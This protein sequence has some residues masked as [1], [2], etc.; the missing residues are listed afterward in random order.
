[1]QIGGI[2]ALFQMVPALASMVMNS[3]TQSAPYTVLLTR[4]VP[5]HAA[6]Q[7]IAGQQSVEY[8]GIIIEA[9]R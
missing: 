8:G 3:R 9:E 5:T 4:F 1:M 6:K 7:A 2:K